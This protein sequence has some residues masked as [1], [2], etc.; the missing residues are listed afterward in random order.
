MARVTVEDCVVRV[1][2]RFELVMVAAQRAR[3]IS[4]GSPLH[5]DR[6]H[7]KNPVVALRE[8]AR[9]LV[10]PEQL[11]EELVQSHRRVLPQDDGEE[12]GV[13]NLF[14][15][16]PPVALPAAETV[17]PA[18]DTPDEDDAVARDVAEDL[19]S[20]EADIEAEIDE[21]VLSVNDGPDALTDDALADDDGSDLN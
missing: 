21:D 1:S 13:E 2:N 7:D 16:E 15:G 8:I 20:A 5:V 18:N 3:D 11:Q 14:A 10:D 6:D 17:I 9:D 4:A 12:E 19:A